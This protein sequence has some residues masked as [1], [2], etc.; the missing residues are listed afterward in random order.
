MAKKWGEKGGETKWKLKV[1]FNKKC[2]NLGVCGVFWKLIF[3]LVTLHYFNI[4]YH[5]LITP[6]I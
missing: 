2:S 6:Q 5:T 1:V 4:H 3:R